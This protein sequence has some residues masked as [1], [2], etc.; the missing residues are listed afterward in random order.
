MVICIYDNITKNFVYYQSHE[1]TGLKE[2]QSLA[3]FPTTKHQIFGNSDYDDL[4]EKFLTKD[5][6]NRIQSRHAKAKNPLLDSDSEDVDSII[7]KLVR[8]KKIGKK[9]VKKQK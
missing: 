1:E 4:N 5:V 2:M 8:P 7:R 9:R 3:K 6:M